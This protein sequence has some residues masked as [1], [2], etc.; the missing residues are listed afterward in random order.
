MD[1]V[2]P[3]ILNINKDLIISAQTR[4]IYNFFKVLQG[5]HYC[6][7]PVIVIYCNTIVIRKILYRY[8]ISVHHRIGD[9]EAISKNATTNVDT[10]T[11]DCSIVYRYR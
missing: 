7:Q 3:G 5:Y 1:F 10:T 6:L 2:F 4:F 11:A 9:D 8:Q